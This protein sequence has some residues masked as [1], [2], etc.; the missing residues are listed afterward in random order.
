MYSSEVAK[1]NRIQQK[2]GKEPK[3]KEELQKLINEAL[4][5]TKRTWVRHKDRD[6]CNYKT[7]PVQVFTVEGK[8]IGEYSSLSQAGEATGVYPAQILKCLRKESEYAK[9][10]VFLDKS[11]ENQAIV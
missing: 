7:H 5:P 11:D 1:Y 10:Y 8:F 9:G 6:T 3:T 2:Y 4:T